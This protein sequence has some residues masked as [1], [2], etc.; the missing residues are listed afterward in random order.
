[1]SALPMPVPDADSPTTRL[2]RGWL[3]GVVAVLGVLALLASLALVV[4]LVAARQH[5]AAAS[6]LAGLG[7]LAWIYLSPRLYAW[8]YVVPGALAALVFIV[9]PMGYTVAI[10]FTNYSSD[11]LLP[12]ERATDVLL[13]RSGD[14][15]AGVDFRIIATGTRFRLEFTDEADQHFTSEPIALDGASAQRVVLTAVGTADDGE[16]LPLKRVIALQAALKQ[17]TAVLPDGSELHQSSLRRFVA[18]R[19]AYVRNADGTLT[20]QAD[21][22][23]VVANR[24]KGY[25]QRA[26]DGRVLQPGFRATVGWENYR[27]IF[28]E[29]R[30]LDPFLRVF[31]WTVSFAAMNTIFTFALGVLLAVALNWDA[32]RGRNFYRMMLFLPYAVPAFISIPVFRGLFNENLGEI[33]LILDQLFGIRPGWFSD[34]TLAR[35]MVLIV[36]TWL[37]YPYMM[38]LS[39]GLIKAIPDELYE[40]SALAGAGP[41]TN[42][43]RITL[44]LIA[45]P[46]APLLIASFATNFNN[47]TLIALLTNGAPDYLDT[48]VPVGA[49]DLLAS[50]TYRIAFQ[51]S[52]QN[53]ALA[54]AIS[55]IVFVIVAS[56]AVFNL[57]LFKVGREE[58]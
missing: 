26:A 6:V 3:H 14:N 38:I 22:T 24:D 48:A 18:S 32:L 17:V 46:I 34:A 41:L 2:R 35:S 53:Y 58:G 7:V 40:A 43:F 5:V 4:L 55:S 45:R 23:R 31:V 29:H 25:W 52:G 11:H 1:M 49:T 21:G 12:F 20:D 39:M 33:N 19:P 50:Y 10:G 8:R 13:S 54:C 9:L 51:D 36:N 30:F 56:L 47:L 28:T 42:L 44:P 27:R 16:A 15:G 57:R 37:G